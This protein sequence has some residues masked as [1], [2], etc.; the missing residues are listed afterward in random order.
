MD[1]GK[2]GVVLTM[3]CSIDSLVTGAS[4]AELELELMAHELIWWGVAGEREAA[5]NCRGRLPVSIISI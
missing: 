5:E 4:S 2:W 3:A 1:L